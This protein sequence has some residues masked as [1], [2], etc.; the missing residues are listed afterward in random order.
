MF[1]ICIILTI[2]IILGTIVYLHLNF[3]FCQAQTCT[4]P[5]FS[6][7]ITFGNSD[8]G[9]FSAKIRLVDAKFTLSVYNFARTLVNH[10]Q[11]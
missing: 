5:A 4:T 9:H 8:W 6:T 11:I 1:G 7:I 3:Q 10:C 2:N